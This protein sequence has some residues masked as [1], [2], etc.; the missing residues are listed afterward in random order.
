PQIETLSN[1]FNL[2]RVCLNGSVREIPVCIPKKKK[3][4][5]KGDGSQKPFPY[6]DLRAYAKTRI[7]L[8]SRR[9]ILLEYGRRRKS[10]KSPGK[11]GCGRGSLRIIQRPLALANTGIGGQGCMRCRASLMHRLSG[12]WSWSSPAQVF[13]V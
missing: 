6:G 1:S 4:D 8:P 11:R 7:S 13:S 12:S 5:S 2:E 10:V 9:S 3:I